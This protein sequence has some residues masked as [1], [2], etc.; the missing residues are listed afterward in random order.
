MAKALQV[1]VRHHGRGRLN[2]AETAYTRILAHDPDNVHARHLLGVIHHQ[3]GDNIAAYD[4]IS[5][6]LETDPRYADAHGNMGHVLTAL[7]RLDE[8]LHH[9]TTQVVLEPTLAEAHNNLGQA[10][11]QAGRLT[12]AIHSYQMAVTLK[13]N[14]AEA[15]CNNGALHQEM[16]HLNDALACYRH[17]LQLRPNYAEALSR[18]GSALAQLGQNDEA[19]A[20]YQEAMRLNPM[21]ATT[22]ANLTSLYISGNADTETAIEGSLRSLKLLQLARYGDGATDSNDTIASRLSSG[23]M[24]LFRLKHDVEQAGYL[25]GQGIEVPGIRDFCDSG[26][27]ILDR[28]TQAI[29]QKMEPSHDTARVRLSRDEAAAMLPYLQTGHLFQLDEVPAFALNP[30][31][32]WRAEEQKYLQSDKQIMYADDFLAPA[33]LKWFQTYCLVSKVWTKEYQNSYLGSFS[34]QGFISPLHLKLASELKE[35][36]P[37]LFGAHPLRRFWG[38]KYDARLGKGINVHADFAQINLNFWITPD[39]YNL[40]TGTG[41]L[42]VYDVPSPA[43][44]HFRAYNESKEAI[45][46]FIAEHEAQ[47]VTVPY[48]CNRAVLFNSA[49]F[50]ETDELH[51][52]DTYEARR[53][54]I[55][56]LFGSR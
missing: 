1:A 42:K 7:G 47:S 4:L 40:A 54:N 51:F 22:L 16:G 46:A 31:I 20:C 32:D 25:L 27:G 6:A 10:L 37:T 17:A 33:A 56:Y 50:H 38:F 52:E 55:T 18:M 34:D 28:A 5:K 9:F 3:R 45:Y 53:I 11:H 21:D 8:A 30:E 2:E 39:I 12:D 24:A 49:Y 13:P 19:V 14:F 29:L 15:H 44:W 41:R 35:K 43:N 48:R 26:Q 36:M 23:D